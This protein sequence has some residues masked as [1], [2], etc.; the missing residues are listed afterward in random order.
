MD[1]IWILAI[2]GLLIVGLVL[3]L[4]FGLK[5]EGYVA[6]NEIHFNNFD[7]KDGTINIDGKNVSINNLQL[8]SKNKNKIV[9][10]GNHP[11]FTFSGSEKKVPLQSSTPNLVMIIKPNG[12]FEILNDKLE[13]TQI[14]DLSFSANFTL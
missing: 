3:G 14:G 2:I 8:V 13:R 7:V 4:I 5:K 10:K 9:I 12:D 11:K 6:T 1:K